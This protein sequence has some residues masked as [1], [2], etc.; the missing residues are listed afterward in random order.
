MTN[1]TSRPRFATSFGVIATTVGSAV[2]LGNIWRFP[3]ETGSNGGAA[4]LIL[5]IIFVLAIGVPLICAEFIMGRSS[6]LNIFGAFRTLAPARGRTWAAVGCLGILAAVLILSF[7][8][9]VAG[10]TFEYLAESLTGHLNDFSGPGRHTAFD[11]FTAGPRC[12]FWT[13]IVLAANAA[14]LLGGVRKGIERVSNILMPILF[15]LLIALSV[16]SLFLPGAS[17]GLSFLFRPDFSALTPAAVLSAMG[18][19][20]FSL[21]LGVGTMM[22]YAS[23]FSSRTPLIRSALTTAALDTLVAILASIMIFPAVFSFGASPEAGPKLVFEVLPDIFAGMPAGSVA[24]AAFFL[25]LVLASITS[26]ISMSEIVVAFLI[27]QWGLRR[28][29][30]VAIHTAICALL[31]SLCALSFGPLAHV[32]IAGFTFFNLF[33]FA[34]SNILMPIGGCLISIFVGWF[35]DRSVINTQLAPAPAALIRIITLTLRYI[36][37]AAIAIIFIAGLV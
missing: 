32:K 21:S 37:P 33:D 18:Q 23:Y 5:Y 1:S 8:A 7:Y 24:A 35:I 13:L 22:I 36:A 14:V 19:A 27:E 28:I 12:L 11:S 20:F 17:V 10:W 34:T 9:V 26:T 3:Y 29:P 30:A 15:V 2:G 6:R 16:N 25:L 4:F 31:A